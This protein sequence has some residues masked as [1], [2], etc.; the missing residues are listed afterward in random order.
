[1]IPPLPEPD[2]QGELPLSSVDAHRVFGGR[3]ALWLHEVASVLSCTE[4][5]VINLIVEFELTGGASGLKGFSIGR[6][7]HK[8][9]TLLQTPRNCWR[10]AV[11]DYDAFIARR[12]DSHHF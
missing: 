11:S 8:P 3:T 2:P 10:V 4:R 6:A 7:G 9:T 12:R 5:H 1:M